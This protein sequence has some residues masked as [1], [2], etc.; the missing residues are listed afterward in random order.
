M[1]ALTFYAYLDEHG[2]QITVQFIATVGNK[3]SECRLSDAC[4]RELDVC[5]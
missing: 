5:S 1:I 2:K 4:L 3:P